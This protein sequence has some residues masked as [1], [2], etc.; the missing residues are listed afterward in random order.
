MIG[1]VNISFIIFKSI[2]HVML[3]AKMIKI[4]M[5]SWGLD[6]GWVI[7]MGLFAFNGSSGIA[8]ISTIV[9]TVLG[10]FILWL[11]CKDWC[12][13]GMYMLY[14]HGNAWMKESK[15][16]LWK[17]MYIHRYICYQKS[18]YSCRIQSFTEYLIFSTCDKHIIW[19]A[20]IIPW[21]S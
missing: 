6:R 21:R 8:V 9:T 13:T 15:Y 20:I 10:R 2:Q 3:R 14:Q 19:R 18:W 16:Q 1:N 17:E 4:P 7:S 11:C 12:D 5:D